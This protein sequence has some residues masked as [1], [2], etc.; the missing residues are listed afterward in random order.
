[1]RQWIRS[2]LVQIMACRLFGAKPS[3]KPMLGSCELTHRNKLQWNFN[4][5]KKLFIHENASENTVCEMAAILSRGR[6]VKW[7]WS[8]RKLKLPRMCSFDI[9][10][11]VWLRVLVPTA[12]IIISPCI[13]G[14][15]SDLINNHLILYL[16][17]LGIWVDFWIVLNRD[18][19]DWKCWI[20]FM[21]TPFLAIRK[22]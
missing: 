20:A 1:M 5:N 16:A 10:F 22:V 17:I 14:K 4:Q 15:G 12:S 6:W 19:R 18:V 3:S 7:Y 8:V 21:K 2:A 11:S 9:V 13:C